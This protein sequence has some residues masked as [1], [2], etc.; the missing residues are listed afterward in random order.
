MRKTK[1]AGPKAK[2]KTMKSVKRAP[3]KAAATKAGKATLSI[4]G[5]LRDQLAAGAKEAGQKNWKAFAT[6]LLNSA[7]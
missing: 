7:F 5:K 4:S 6:T 3:A 2:R 1:K